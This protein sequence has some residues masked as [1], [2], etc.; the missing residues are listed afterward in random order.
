MSHFRDLA[1]DT[2]R[3]MQN[4]SYIRAQARRTGA[5]IM[6]KWEQKY[7]G[8][9]PNFIEKLKKQIPT[10]KKEGAETMNAA[11][12]AAYGIHHIFFNIFDDIFVNN[13]VARRA[14]QYEQ[15]QEGGKE[16]ER[17][18]REKLFTPTDYRSKPRHLQ[19]LYALLRKEMVKS[20]QVEITEE[21]QEV[22]NTPLRF[23]GREYTP[24][25]IIETFI[26]TRGGRDT[27]AGERYFILQHTL[28]PVFN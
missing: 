3:I 16:V 28:E 15:S 24:R 22:L 4:F 7:S 9:D 20:E 8:T 12:R 26:L 11:E 19:F 6:G 1:E 2:E 10:S 14:P 17:L 13:M 23:Q 27:K 18:Y 5:V 21:V 25:E